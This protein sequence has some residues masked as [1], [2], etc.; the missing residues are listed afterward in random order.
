LTSHDQFVLRP[1]KFG[2]LLFKSRDPLLLFFHGAK[3]S[4]QPSHPASERLAIH[5]QRGSAFFDPGLV[6]GIARRNS[7]NRPEYATTRRGHVSGS[8]A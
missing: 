8:P 1:V 5:F 7:A 3:C 2:E 4:P 6:D